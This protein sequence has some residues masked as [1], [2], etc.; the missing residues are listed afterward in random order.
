MLLT[1]NFICFNSSFSVML[2]SFVDAV[3]DQYAVLLLFTTKYFAPLILYASLISSPMLFK[4]RLW[5]MFVY[6]V[7][8]SKLSNCLACLVLFTF[9]ELLPHCL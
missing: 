8:K 9:V 7:E 5:G 6:N 2:W 1:K 3:L 4:S